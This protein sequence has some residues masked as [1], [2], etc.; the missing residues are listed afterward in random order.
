M[1]V[2]FR[3]Q[4]AAEFAS[5]NCSYTAALAAT[6]FYIV[7]RTGVFTTYTRLNTSL[8]LHRGPELDG[9]LE[10]VVCVYVCM[11]VVLCCCCVASSAALLPSNCCISCVVTSNCCISCVVTSNCCIS[12]VSPVNTK[13]QI[14]L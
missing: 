10:R 4:L 12:C 1:L 13:Y 3:Q 7:P 6:E 9:D 5:R 14:Y 8:R 11:Y 2:T